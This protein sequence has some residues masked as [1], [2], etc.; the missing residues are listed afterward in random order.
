M[1]EPALGAVAVRPSISPSTLLV[2]AIAAGAPGG[3]AT[4]LPWSCCNLRQG[5]HSKPHEP[6]EEGRPGYH[7][8]VT[9]HLGSLVTC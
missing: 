5:Q 7:L 8:V 2:S 3:T 6:H 1:R 9:V 4:G